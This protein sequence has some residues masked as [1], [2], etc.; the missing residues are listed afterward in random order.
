MSSHAAVV[1][2][3][4]DVLLWVNWVSAGAAVVWSVWTRRWPTLS[5]VWLVFV[6]LSLACWLAQ[7]SL[8]LAPGV[9]TY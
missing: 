4:L 3:A 5:G 1:R 7:M 9:G 6:S 8:M 2:L